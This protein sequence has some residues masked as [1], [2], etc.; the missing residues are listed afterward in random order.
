ML[1]V[2]PSA[3]FFAEPHMESLI[4]YAKVL[5]DA[6]VNWTFSSHASEAGNFGMFIG[7]HENMRKIAL[8]IRKAAEELERQA[9][10]VRRMRPRLARRLQF[11]Q[12]ARRA[13]STSSIPPI[14]SRSTSASSPGT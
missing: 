4:G 2:T 11:P 9:H 10:R 7:N 8:R 6:G 3:D 14:R 13:R 1:L 12:H 5:H